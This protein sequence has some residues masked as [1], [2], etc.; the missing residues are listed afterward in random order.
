MTRG[1]GHG[2]LDVGPALPG[3][4]HDYGGFLGLGYVQRPSER[5][6]RTAMLNTRALGCVDEQLEDEFLGR[7]DTARGRHT[8]VDFLT[9]SRVRPSP[10]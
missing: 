10:R 2:L 1:R 5:V 6:I 3:C 4:G 9:T 8:F 7:M